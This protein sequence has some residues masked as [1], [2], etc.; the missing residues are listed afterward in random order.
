MLSGQSKPNKYLWLAEV[1]PQLLLYF[2]SKTWESFLSKNKKTI[3]QRQKLRSSLQKRQFQTVWTWWA[4]NKFKK[5]YSI[6]F[7]KILQIKIG[8]YADICLFEAGFCFQRPFKFQPVECEKM[9]FRIFKLL[10]LNLG[11]VKDSICSQ[12]G[13]SHA[14]KI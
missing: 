13:K 14:L 8:F 11:Y 7:S 6:F 1:C 5:C 12:S 3:G 9:F 2:F 10:P 4:K